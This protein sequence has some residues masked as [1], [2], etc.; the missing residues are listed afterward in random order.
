[1][2]ASRSATQPE[3]GAPPLC[4]GDPHPPA[5]FLQQVVMMGSAISGVRWQ[6][7][8]PPGPWMELAD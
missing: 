4:N 6:R 8:L 2:K 7:T 3:S 1:M 5:H